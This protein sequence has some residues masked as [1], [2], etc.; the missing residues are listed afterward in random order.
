MRRWVRSLL[1]LALLVF[2]LVLVSLTYLEDVAETSSQ[3]GPEGI[4]TFVSNLPRRVVDV[5]AQAGYLG[6]FALILLEAA[7]LPVPSE[8]ILLFASFMVS[9]RISDFWS[10]VIVST[11]AA[12]IG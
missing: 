12:L 4:I 6:I 9:Q 5:A 8:I 1:I 2:P 11:L 3:L 10:V 7:A